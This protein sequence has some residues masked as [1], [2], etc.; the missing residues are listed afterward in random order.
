EGSFKVVDKAETVNVEL[1]KE[2]EVPSTYK[3]TFDIKEGETTVEDAT[4]EVKKD[5]TV[6][7][8][9][10]DGTYELEVGDYTYTVTKEGY[11]TAE[12][13]FKVVDKAET[14]NVELVREPVVDLTVANVSDFDELKAAIEST[15]VITINIMNDINVTEKLDIKSEKNINGNNHALTGNNETGWQG[16]YILHFYKTK[17][18]VKNIKLTGAD[19]AIYVNGSNVSLEGT[20]DVGGN[21]FGGIEVSK[22][23]GV[24]EEPKLNISTATLVNSTEDNNIPTVWEDKIGTKEADNR[25]TGHDTM[26]VDYNQKTESN[27]QRFYYLNDALSAPNPVE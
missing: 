8:A 9:E 24:T 18:N 27:I 5:G 26:K 16:F 19:A 25:V 17:G 21:E 6:V 4:V 13:S 23:E 3:I 12:G 22:G 10:A 14:V 20:V 1:V 7:T 15:E 2:E 11:K